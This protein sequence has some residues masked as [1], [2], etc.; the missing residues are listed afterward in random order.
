MINDGCGAL[1]GMKI[2]R[3]TEVLGENLPQCH[4]VH[5][6]TLTTRPGIEAG[7]PE[8]WHGLFNR[9]TT[10]TNTTAMNNPMCIPPVSTVNQLASRICSDLSTRIVRKQSTNKGKTLM[11]H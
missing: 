2:G 4:F 1:G 3:E 5:H 9:L 8:L 7:T 6:K 11:N 10:V